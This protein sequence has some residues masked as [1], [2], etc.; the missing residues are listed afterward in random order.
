MVRTGGA[1]ARPIA[2]A[3]AAILCAAALAA[4][5]GEGVAPTVRLPSPPPTQAG[6]GPTPTAYAGDVFGVVL[7]G[8]EP[9]AGARVD[10]RLPDWQTAPDPL[11][12][13]TLSGPDGRFL[14]SLPPIGDWAV[15][16]LFPDGELDALGWSSMRLTEGSAPPELVIELQRALPLT[17]PRPGEEVPTRTTLAWEAHPGATR[18][19]VVVTDAGTTAAVVDRTTPETRLDLAGLT[20]DRTYDWSVEALDAAGHS[21]AYGAS[22]IVVLHALDAESTTVYTDRRITR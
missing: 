17:R 7:Y 18:Y 20:P 1:S 14:F 16:A 11:V 13:S 4:C 19:H 22:R 5:A 15:V 8:G 9:V 10:L 2:H 3:L 6:P 21:L 12:A